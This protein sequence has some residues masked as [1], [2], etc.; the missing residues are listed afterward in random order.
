[1]AIDRRLNDLDFSQLACGASK[2]VWHPDTGQFQALKEE[3]S[4]PN[5]PPSKTLA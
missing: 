4:R 2:P 1:M 3:K 5:T